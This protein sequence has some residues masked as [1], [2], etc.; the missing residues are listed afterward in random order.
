MMT[1]LPQRQS[2]V[3]QALA[4]LKEQIRSGTWDNWF[5]GEWDLCAQLKISR[6]TLRAALGQLE[7]EGLLRA[8][9]G[10]RRRVAVSSRRIRLGPSNNRVT[11]LTPEPLS[12]LP[13]LSMFWIDE[14]R[15][16]LHAAGCQLEVH[17]QRDPQA[18]PP[19]GTLEQLVKRTRASVWVLASY[20]APVQQWFS[21]KGLPCLVVGSR[22]EGVALPS[23]DIGYRALSRHAAGLLLAR[24]HT[25]LALL[26]PESGLA[27]DLESERGFLEAGEHFQRGGGEFLIGHHDGTRESVCKRLDALLQL[28]ASPTGFLV[29]GANYALMTLCFLL[30]K[31][32]RLP[33]DVAL[34]S[35]NEELFLNY[36][37][38]SIAH[39]SANPTLLARKVSRIV[40]QLVRGGVSEP[41]DYRLMPEFVPGET[42][43]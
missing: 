28:R 24:G 10:R 6:R 22:H 11:L 38:P 31:G 30:G 17:F 8:G 15:E 20:T 16:H 19:I 2:L 7:R 23:V 32:L 3:S 5:P 36:A 1:P 18:H 33:R 40:M 29:S 26:N 27:G 35:R 42:L 39:Y 14:L 21:R 25:R 9:K 41:R 4:I 13:P 37:L 12:I 43:G 34:I